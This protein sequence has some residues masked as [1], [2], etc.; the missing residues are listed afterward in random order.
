MGQGSKTLHPYSINISC[1]KKLIV[2]S[3]FK[4]SVSLW[5]L[6]CHFSSVLR[7]VFHILQHLH[8]RHSW[9]STARGRSSLHKSNNHDIS[10]NIP[11][12]LLILFKIHNYKNK[13]LVFQ[14][15]W[16]SWL[17]GFTQLLGQSLSR[18]TW[19]CF[20]FTH[21]QHS[22]LELVREGKESHKTGLE[23][24]TGPATYTNVLS[25]FF[26]SVWISSLFHLIL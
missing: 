6:N 10:H 16:V 26:W 12:V 19:M 21:L 22:S 4:S 3:P 1:V 9:Y 15:K 7:V 23:D 24:I 25:S 17:T 5:L 2:E 8:N 14:Q 11:S 18:W 13:I 20:C